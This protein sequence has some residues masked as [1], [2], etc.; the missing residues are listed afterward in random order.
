MLVIKLILLYQKI[1]LTP[2]YAMFKI[3]FTL[4]LTM[5][6][7]KCVSRIHIIVHDKVIYVKEYFL[8]HI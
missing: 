2:T 8:L 4:T 1:G 3:P 7:K 5:D 6:I